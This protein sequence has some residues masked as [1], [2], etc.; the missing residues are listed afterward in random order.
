MNSLDWTRSIE[1]VALAATSDTNRIIGLAGMSRRS[2]VS[3]IGRSLAKS[4]AAGELR[5]L[6]VDLNPDS[7]AVPN[8]HGAD[9]WAPGRSKAQSWIRT[10]PDGYDVLEVRT[11]PQ[12]RPLFSN[13]A[14]L[15]EVFA[16]EFAEYRRVI[17][18]LPPVAES[19]AGAVNPVAVAGAC[20]AVLLVVV[21]GRDMRP[22]VVQAVDALRAAGVR[23]SGA[24]ANEY[25]WKSAEE[26]FR[27]AAELAR[28][29]IVAASRRIDWQ[30][31]RY[32]WWR[33]KS[34]AAGAERS[35]QNASV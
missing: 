5:T 23:V 31:S 7:D 14:R 22:Q 1:Q 9:G 16:E 10:T 13:L 26:E 25:D 2:G 27:L 21:V 8:P 35:D 11:T 30:P 28:K 18:E 33:K 29:R 20:D 15:R 3:L 34:D 19:E 6:R 24:I 4:L 32:M 12:T 17:V